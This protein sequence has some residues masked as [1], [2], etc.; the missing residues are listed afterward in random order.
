MGGK[1]YH[2]EDQAAR[3]SP[4]PQKKVYHDSRNTLSH[5]SYTVAWICALSIEMAAARAMLDDVHESLPKDVNDS[6][7]YVLGSIGQ[8]NVAIA[9]LP[10]GQYGTNNAAIVFTNMWRTFKYI[11][12]GL[13]VG[14]GGGAPGKADLRLGDIVVGSKVIQHDMG[15][16]IGDDRLLRTS[17]PRPLRNSVSTEVSSLRSKHYSSPSRVP[18]ILLERSEQLR[19]FKR[20]VSADRLFKDT[21]QHESSI[22]DCASCDQSKLV[23]RRPRDS[24]DPVIHYGAIASGNLV[25]K[26]SQTR[27]KLAQDLDV[28]CFEMEAAGL[29]DIGACLPVRGICDYSDSHKTKEWQ[30]YAAATAAA[31]AREFLEEL[32]V[33]KVFSEHEQQGAC[34]LSVRLEEKDNECLRDLRITNPKDDKETIVKAKGGLLDESYRWVMENESYQQW[35]RSDENRLLWIKGDPGKGKTMLLCGIIDELERATPH[36][37]FYFFCQAS[38]PRLRSASAVL[39]GLIWFLA[40]TRPNLMSYIRKEYDQAGKDVFNDHNSW[41]A[42]SSILAS[43]LEDDTTNDCIFVVDALDECS[44]DRERLIEFL[45]RLSSSS[46]S[47]WIVSSR[48]WPE[49]EA[50]LDTT[51][52][53][54]LHLELNHSSIADAVQKFIT[55]KVKDLAKNKRYTESIRDA[56][57]QHLLLN[58]NDTFLWVSL[59]CEELGKPGVLLHHTLKILRC[60]PAGLDKLYQRMV[61]KILHSM[62]EEFCRAILAVVTVA[63]EPLSLA[64]LATSDE[65]LACF[66]SELQTLSTIVTCCGSF[67]TIRNNVV[68][69]VHQ[70]VKDYLVTSSDIFPSSIAGQHYS[71]FRNTMDRMHA[72]LQRNIYDVHDDTL[73]IHEISKPPSSPL[74]SIRYG[75]IYWVDHLHKSAPDSIESPPTYSLLETFFKTKYLYWLEAMS[76]LGCVSKAIRAIRKLG[77]AL[78]RI[79]PVEVLPSSS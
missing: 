34:Q 62:D 49:I 70:S 57:L 37:V 13:M 72:A 60:S 38:E 45:S 20:P 3:S 39:R 27:D 76:L 4:R 22:P 16:A 69:T 33:C 59:V 41:Q 35:A 74:D 1:R 32:P 36:S 78:V 26:D 30:A 7:S 73:Y 23:K 43:I 11:Q 47:K 75:C 52:K 54:R 46:K 61:D 31:Y 15:K 6:N 29:M 24:D 66:H 53:V 9:C 5:D 50:Q 12:L 48:N 77:S 8:H 51:T 14:I 17:I 67:L 44:S 42:L 56:V 2:N 10:N 63:F 18:S 19:N 40:R 25:I 71:V 58:A 28:I 55:R 21:Y 79:G 68:Y 65:R 64:E